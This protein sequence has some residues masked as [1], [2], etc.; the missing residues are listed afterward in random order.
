[1]DIN[2]SFEISGKHVPPWRRGQPK[3]RGWIH[4]EEA[5]SAKEEEG[6]FAAKRL[7]CS[8]LYKQPYRRYNKTNAGKE[9]TFF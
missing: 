9:T 6:A 1:M 2:S 8:Y 3:G 4:L 5:E 7:F